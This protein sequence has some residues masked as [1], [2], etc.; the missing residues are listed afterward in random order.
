M[1]T[2]FAYPPTQVLT[3][4]N[5][6]QRRRA[7]RSWLVEILVPVLLT[8]GMLAIFNTIK[9]RV[10][11]ASVPGNGVSVRFDHFYASY[12]APQCTWYDSNVFWR[13]PR[14][15]ACEDPATQCERLVFAMAPAVAGDAAAM[16][17]ATQLAA[18]VQELTDNS[19]PAVVFPSEKALEDYILQP[20]YALNASLPNIGVAVIFDAGAPAWSYHLRTNRTVNGGFNYLL[21]PTKITTDALLRTGYDMP[22]SCPRCDMPYGQQ[23]YFS[24]GLA[25]QNLVDSFIVSEAA[26]APIQLTASVVDFPAPGYTEAGCVWVSFGR[27]VGAIARVSCGAYQHPQMCMNART[28]LDPASFSHAYVPM[29]KHRFWGVVSAFY[30]IFMVIAVLYPVSNV[31]RSLVME[32]GTCLGRSIDRSILCPCPFHHPSKAIIESMDRPIN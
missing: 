4:K 26:G 6:I 7:L 18:R 12:G 1:S 10:V 3:W 5:N 14:R 31:V 16:T 17:A 20:G 8:V 9:P 27:V 23:W 11:P 2:A 28:N 19:Q 13:C 15:E 25:V 30:G 29:C 21:P 32:K 22:K 24:G